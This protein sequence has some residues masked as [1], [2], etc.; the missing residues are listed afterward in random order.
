MK[1]TFIC[2]FFYSFQLI[3]NKF[4]NSFK[5]LIFATQNLKGKWALYLIFS[6][7]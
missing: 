7:C 2:R 4:Y 6:W 1:A 3:E 5:L